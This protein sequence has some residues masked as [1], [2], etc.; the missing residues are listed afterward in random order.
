MF[1]NSN[2]F[3]LLVSVVAATAVGVVVKALTAT[4]EG[5]DVEATVGVAVGMEEGGMA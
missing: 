1:V 3:I 2:V 5:Q 4:V